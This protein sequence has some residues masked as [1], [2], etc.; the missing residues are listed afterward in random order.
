MRAGAIAQ[1]LALV[2][3]SAQD[4]EL[5]PGV[6]VDATVAMDGPRIESNA[7][8]ARGARSVPGTRL[9]LVPEIDG[10]HHVE[11]GSWEFGSHL[12]LRDADGVVLA[13]VSNA[14]GLQPLVAADLRA[15]ASYFVEV[16][17]L[18]AEGGRFEVVCRAGPPG[19][20]TAGERMARLEAEGRG[21]SGMMA[22]TLI[23]M[24]KGIL[25]FGD[26]DRS[27]ELMERALAIRIAYFGPDHYF[28]AAT[29]EQT[30]WPLRRALR[31][32]EALARLEAAADIWNRDPA[33]GA[34]A[35]TSI[36]HEVGRIHK[37]RGE[38]EEALASYR[39]A[40][41]TYD[42]RVVVTGDDPVAHKFEGGIYNSLAVV[43]RMLGRWGEAREAYER[44]LELIGDEPAVLTNFA[45][46]LAGQGDLAR[47]RE[48]FEKA[49]DGLEARGLAVSPVAGQVWND[50][51]TFLLDKLGD[52]NEATAALNR[53][54]ALR[55]QTLGPEHP[56]VGQ[57][58]NN[59]G[60]VLDRTG[61]L[62]RASSN[63]RGG[64]SR[65]GWSCPSARWASGIPRRCSFARTS[66]RPCGRPATW[67]KRGR[68]STRRSRS[69]RG[70]SVPTIRT[71]SRRASS[72]AWCSG[73]GERTRRR[74][75]RSKEP[76]PPRGA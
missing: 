69:R 35:L 58:Y 43:L 73:R 53:A 76:M 28:V 64:L 50:Y 3:L 5:V 33:T 14:P 8:R 6:W 66:Q 71:P 17:T 68:F 32:D 10:L 63:G 31:Y 34:E 30:A 57:T 49:L 52:R 42:A 39:L 4:A 12:I 70:P 2:A 37:D 40:L 11:A 25:Q 36:H 22:A 29:L 19:S 67:T 46:L 16:G 38:L 20:R 18:A 23:E 56:H 45:T 54:L 48:Y 13:E 26:Y 15:G 59:L 24:A 9:R 47:A 72:S 60:I 51:G 74:S 1:A 41:A 7:L 75:R 21:E 44:A 62:E 65:A 55:V 27:A 61:E